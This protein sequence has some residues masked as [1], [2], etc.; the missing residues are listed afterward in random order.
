MNC[1]RVWAYIF[2]AVLFSATTWCDLAMASITKVTAT[3]D[4]TKFSNCDVITRICTEEAKTYTYSLY[5]NN[6]L[7]FYRHPGSPDFARVDNPFVKIELKY[8]SDEYIFD[9]PMLQTFEQI[10]VRSNLSLVISPEQAFV[11]ALLLP[12]FRVFLLRY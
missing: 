3:G 5:Y 11:G 10:L 9:V 7:P 2:A 6:Q 4:G 1:N 8:G 12:S